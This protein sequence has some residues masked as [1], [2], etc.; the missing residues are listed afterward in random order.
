MDLDEFDDILNSIELKP[1]SES[2]QAARIQ[3]NTA[4]QEAAIPSNKIKS[5]KSKKRA[6]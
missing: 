1:K 4:P 6:E 5:K 3:K 2:S